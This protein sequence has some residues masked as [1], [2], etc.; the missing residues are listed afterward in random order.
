VLLVGSVSHVLA[1]VTVGASA[2][3]VGRALDDL[4]EDFVAAGFVL[5]VV[6]VGRR[7]RGSGGDDG[8]S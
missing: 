6:Y 5:V 7:W 3:E 4:V 2:A 8:D 1:A